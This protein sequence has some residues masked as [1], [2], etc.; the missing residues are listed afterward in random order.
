VDGSNGVGALGMAEMA[1]HIDPKILQFE[2][3]NDG[4]NGGVLNFQVSDSP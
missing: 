4:S 3:I 2:I 1:K